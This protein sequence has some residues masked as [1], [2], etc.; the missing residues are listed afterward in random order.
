MIL[1]TPIPCLSAQIQASGLLSL[2]I[3][4]SLNQRAVGSTPTRPTKINHL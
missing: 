3:G 4:T 2:A 1:I